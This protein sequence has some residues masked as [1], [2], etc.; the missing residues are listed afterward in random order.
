MGDFDC[1]ANAVIISV[2]ISFVMPRVLLNFA[3]PEE[4]KLPQQLDG[5]SEK[6]K[7]MHLMAHKE[8][9][10]LLSAAIVGFI[11]GLSVYLGY[12]LKPVKMVQS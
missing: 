7:L 12:E 8:Q 11:V 1:V 3:K 9:M 4:I 2:I 5:L 10:P 6:E